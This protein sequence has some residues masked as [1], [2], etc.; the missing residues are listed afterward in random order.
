MTDEI[1]S[2]SALVV[3]LRRS[4]D[5]IEF[6]EPEAADELYALI[7]RCHIDALRSSNRRLINQVKTLSEQLEEAQVEVA[8]LTSQLEQLR[9]DFHVTLAESS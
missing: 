2:H 7:T 5:R 3:L 4:I 8:S 1:A 9:M 6:M